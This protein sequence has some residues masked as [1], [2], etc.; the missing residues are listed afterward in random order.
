MVRIVKKEFP[1]WGRILYRGVRGA[2][3]TAMTQTLVL[4]V[5]WSNPQ[6][7]VKAFGVSFLSGFMVALGMWV[8]DLMGE[9]NIVSKTMPI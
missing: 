7:A 2:V 5:D 4:K 9:T 1:E 6:E 8:R 3:V